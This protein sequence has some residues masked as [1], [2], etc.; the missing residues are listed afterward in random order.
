MSPS[1]EVIYKILVGWSQTT[2][3]Q[4]YKSL[5]EEYQNMT[6]QWYEPHGS[7]DK[8]LGEINVRLAEINAPPITVLVF[9]KGKNEPG[10]NFWGCADN[11]PEKPKNDTQ[12]INKVFEIVK[13]V[14]EYHW[15]ANLP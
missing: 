12:R 13:D 10:G 7:W 3:P 9:L 4:Y 15:P 2:G 11:V 8:P 6:G 14:K 1:V 5:S